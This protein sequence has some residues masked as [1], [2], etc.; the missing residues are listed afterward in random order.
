MLFYV[1]FLSCLV[2]F[3]LLL[4]LLSFISAGFSVSFCSLSHVQFS[5]SLSSASCFY[6]SCKQLIPSAIK[7]LLDIFGIAWWGARILP[8]E[9]TLITFNL[10]TKKYQ[11][12]WKRSL[13][14]CILLVWEFFFFLCRTT[15]DEN[16]VNVKIKM[17]CA[18]RF[19]CSDF[20]FIDI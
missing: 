9:K 18:R 8:L 4:R 1:S 10:N 19:W 7:Y 6:G 12:P 13:D 14:G 20:I 16:D 5:Y 15:K 2:F 3:N 17:I 11:L